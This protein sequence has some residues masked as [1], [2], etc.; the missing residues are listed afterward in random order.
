M[1]GPFVRATQENVVLQGVVMS[2]LCKTC[3]QTGWPLGW[4]VSEG[5]DTSDGVEVKYF[6]DTPFIDPF[7]KYS[8]SADCEPGD[9]LGSWDSVHSYALSSQ[10]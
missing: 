7:S 2:P 4:V 5:T 9:C 6:I 10:S 1:T 8:L 3:K